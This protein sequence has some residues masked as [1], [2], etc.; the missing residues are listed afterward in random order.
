MITTFILLKL[1]KNGANKKSVK[2]INPTRSTKQEEKLTRDMEARV[3]AMRKKVQLTPD[4]LKMNLHLIL[5]L[6][7]MNYCAEPAKMAYRRLHLLPRNQRCPYS[8]HPP[9]CERFWILATPAD[10]R[11]SPHLLHKESPP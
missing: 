2:P 4:K 5:A 7:A 6:S 10:Y 9:R 1:D 11:P 8:L 3:A